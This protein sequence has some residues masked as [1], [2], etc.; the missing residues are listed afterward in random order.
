M[1]RLP[2]GPPETLLSLEQVRAFLEKEFDNERFMKAACLAEDGVTYQVTLKQL[3]DEITS[4]NEN[5]ASGEEKQEAKVVEAEDAAA[6]TPSGSRPQTAGSAKSGSRPQTGSGS[7]PTSEQG[8]SRPT[9]RAN[10]PKKNIRAI[11][12]GRERE[13]RQPPPEPVLL[14]PRAQEL[15][16]EL[17]DKTTKLRLMQR[18]R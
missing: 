9:S 5:S 3:M 14:P 8:G 12:R 13:D 11:R 7:R 16:A 6:P 2:E 18:E 1:T 4:L 15:V 17:A 10:D